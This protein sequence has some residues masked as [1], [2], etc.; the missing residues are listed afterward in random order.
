[1]LADGSMATQAHPRPQLHQ[2]TPPP[3]SN[4]GAGAVGGDGVCNIKLKRLVV[5]V[6]EV[7]VAA[8]AAA[9]AFNLLAVARAHA[10]EPQV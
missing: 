1:M 5:F 10:V 2:D 3:A 4:A 8:S 6:R 7:S 9:A